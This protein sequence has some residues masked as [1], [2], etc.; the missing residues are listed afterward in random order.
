MKKNI[1][2]NLYDLIF[3]NDEKVYDLT[4]VKIKEVDEFTGDI[5]LS[6]EYKEDKS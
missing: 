3:P 6:V 4:N 2:V 5:I 1:K